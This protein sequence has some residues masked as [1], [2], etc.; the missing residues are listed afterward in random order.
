MNLG[1]FV[2]ITLKKIKNK[3]RS[4][5][6]NLFA[7]VINLIFFPAVEPKIVLLEMQLHVT[8]LD[9]FSDVREHGAFYRKMT[10]LKERFPALLECGWN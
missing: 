8:N 5:S 1:F 9:L 6:N 2:P 4:D 10:S 3:I 7:N